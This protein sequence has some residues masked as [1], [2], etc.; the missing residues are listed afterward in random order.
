MAV[1]EM[2]NKEINASA[3]VVGGIIGSSLMNVVNS[4][5]NSPEKAFGAAAALAY[6]STRF[7]TRD[8]NPRGWKHQLVTVGVET[9]KTACVMMLPETVHRKDLI[10][11]ALF[12]IG[13]FSLWVPAIRLWIDIYNKKKEKSYSKNAQEDDQIPPIQSETISVQEEIRRN[14]IREK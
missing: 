6:I 13:F 12:A 3:E 11:K 8:N 2:Y 9:V 4:G 1:R 14:E 5:I 7:I 10:G